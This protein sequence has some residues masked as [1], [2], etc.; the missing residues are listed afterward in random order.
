MA[1][2]LQAQAGRMLSA[3]LL[4]AKASLQAPLAHLRR[5]C[6]FDAA[7]LPLPPGKN[8]EVLS[9]MPPSSSTVLPSST[10][11]PAVQQSARGRVRQ[12]GAVRLILLPAHPSIAP[13]ANCF[14]TADTN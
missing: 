3:A 9:P 10:V 1:L 8:T 14:C 11:P 7:L 6:N 2:L 13:G 5:L 4:P 12:S